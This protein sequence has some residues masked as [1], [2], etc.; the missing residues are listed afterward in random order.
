MTVEQESLIILLR[1][2]FE[3]IFRGSWSVHKS[4]R[5]P[6][7]TTQHQHPSRTPA[8]CNYTAIMRMMKEGSPVSAY[9]LILLVASAAAAVFL[10]NHTPESQAPSPSHRRLN[11]LD[12]KT[13]LLKDPLQLQGQGQVDHPLC[14]LLPQVPDDLSWMPVPIHERGTPCSSHAEGIN[15]KRCCVGQCRKSDTIISSDQPA[16]EGLFLKPDMQ[17]LVSMPTMLEHLHVFVQQQNLERINSNPRNGRAH[18]IDTCV[19]W[20]IGQSLTQDQAS[21][22]ICK[23]TSL[24]YEIPNK[25]KCDIDDQDGL[26]SG[27]CEL[28]SQSNQY[29]PKIRVRHTY[30]HERWQRKRTS[31]VDEAGPIIYNYGVRANSLEKF[32]EWMERKFTDDDFQAIDQVGRYPFMWREHEPQHFATKDGSYGGQASKCQDSGVYNNY[33]NEAALRFF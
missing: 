15:L 17:D 14:Q 29:C 25:K 32:D 16:Y 28:T 22:A 12:P 7:P 18:P 9:S 10:L 20:Y 24:G 5:K 33:R 31:Y 8:L 30:V 27:T 2:F 26:L 11:V 21:A 13:V 3:V 1:S 23:L 19:L 6:Q 4:D